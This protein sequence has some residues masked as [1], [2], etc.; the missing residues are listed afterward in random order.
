VKESLQRASLLLTV[1]A[2]T[3]LAGIL[4]S[5]GLTGSSKSGATALT[6]PVLSISTSSLPSGVVGQ[7]YSATLQASG[8]TTPYTWSVALGSLPAGLSLDGSTGAITGTPSSVS[9]FNFTVQVTDANGLSATRGLSITITST[10]GSVGCGALDGGASAYDQSTCGNV[11]T[12]GSVLSYEPNYVDSSATVVSTCGSTFSTAGSY[13]LTADLNCG[14]SNTAFTLSPGSGQSGFYFNLNGRTITGIVSIPPSANYPNDFHLFG[15]TINCNGSH[16]VFVQLSSGASTLTAP[17]V[18]HHLVGNNAADAG[19]IFHLEGSMAG[20]LSPYSFIVHHVECIVSGGNT[21]NDRTGCI[22]MAGNNHTVHY[23]NNYIHNSAGTNHDISE[24]MVCYCSQTCDVEHN[25]VEWN[26]DTLLNGTPG[27]AILL[28]GDALGNGGSQCYTENGNVHHNYL[29]LQ[30]TRG[31]RQRSARR[32]NA[33]DNLFDNVTD[34]NGT[35]SYFGAIHWG[36]PTAP[37]SGNATYDYLNSIY[38]NNRFVLIGPT[39]SGGR[40]AQGNDAINIE[41][42]NNRISCVSNGCSSN[43]E[44]GSALEAIIQSFSGSTTYFNVKVCNFTY[45]QPLATPLYADGSGQTQTSTINNLSA[46]TCSAV[47]NASCVAA[48]SCP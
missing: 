40:V 37:A 12:D 30:N 6:A 13:K 47:S 18:L 29:S 35:L 20:Q 46:G 22:A 9:T 1:V 48:P 4:A 36:N 31:I 42:A 17:V 39:T 45:D 32:V 27:R 25:R 21:I 16:C 19:D 3:S 23:Y 26:A 15:G 7:A 8:G 24:G 5:C 44:N 41:W 2:L 10:S 43:V 11:I 14:A 33:H 34:G 38:Q 28:D